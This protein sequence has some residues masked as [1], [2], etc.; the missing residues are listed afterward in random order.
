MPGDIQ[1]TPGGL[2]RRGSETSQGFVLNLFGRR[3]TCREEEPYVLPRS[4]RP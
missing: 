2:G 3:A 1:S 4:R